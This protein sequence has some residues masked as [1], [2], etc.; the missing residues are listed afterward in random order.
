MIHST[1]PL[2]T[3]PLFMALDFFSGVWRPKS[4]KTVLDKVFSEFCSQYVIV[5][6]GLWSFLPALALVLV[7]FWIFRKHLTP[8]KVG[9]PQVSSSSLPSPKYYCQQ[10]LLSA[11]CYLRSGLSIQVGR[12]VDYTIYIYIYTSMG[13]YLKAPTL[14]P[15]MN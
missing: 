10:L 6:S 13:R 11:I 3:T 7:L 9:R 12:Q 4:R 14:L 8:P 2:H 1:N 5:V 15:W